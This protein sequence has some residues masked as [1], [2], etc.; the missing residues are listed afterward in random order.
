MEGSSVILAI[1]VGNTNR[2]FFIILLFFLIV[3]VAF[4]KAKMTM[5]G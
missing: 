1:D 3:M 2:W 5:I 4:Q